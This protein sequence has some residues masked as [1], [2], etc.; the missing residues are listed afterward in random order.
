L[1]PDAFVESYPPRRVN[2][3]YFDTFDLG[4]LNDHLNGVGERSKLRFRWYGDGYTAVHGILELKHRSNRLGWKSYCPI[5]L[6]FDLTT[7]SWKDL[8]GYMRAFAE[9]EHAAVL[10]RADRPTLLNGLI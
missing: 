8:L 2:N 10:A 6:T 5:P 4:S 1:H 9:G 7:I 3:L